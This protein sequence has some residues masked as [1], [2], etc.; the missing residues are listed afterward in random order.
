M[1]FFFCFYCTCI[2]G[3]SICQEL[4][5]DEDEEEG[6]EEEGG[7][8]ED[9]TG[10]LLH[11]GEVQTP[12]QLSNALMKALKVGGADKAGPTQTQQQPKNQDD[13]RKYMVMF[14]AFP[15]ILCTCTWYL[16]MV[17]KFAKF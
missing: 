8:Q 6:R 15:H 4:A 2:S 9:P 12:V 16:A 5:L 3:L 14:H 7:E 11:T 10:S 17:Q 1:I 13:K